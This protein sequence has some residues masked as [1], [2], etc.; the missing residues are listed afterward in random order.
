METL[1]S[2]SNDHLPGLLTIE[3]WQLLLRF[4]NGADHVVG[5]IPGRMSPC[6]LDLV[7]IMAK[8]KSLVMQ[9]RASGFALG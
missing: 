4:S 1:L 8:R 5:A 6:W 7:D 9:E 2:E 3:D